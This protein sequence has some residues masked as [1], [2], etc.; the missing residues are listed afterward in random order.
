MCRKHLRTQKKINNNSLNPLEYVPDLI[1]NTD[2]FE[3]EHY[4]NTLHYRHP[5]NVRA[6]RLHTHK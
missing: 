6:I 5:D 1:S 4:V 3:T 2:R